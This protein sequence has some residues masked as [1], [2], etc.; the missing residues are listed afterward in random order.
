IVGRHT[1][2]AA[3]NATTLLERYASPII[4]GEPTGSS[5]NFVGEDNFF[6][7]PFSKMSVSVSDLYWQASWPQDERVWI[8]PLLLAPPTWDSYRRNVDP[9]MEA[10]KKFKG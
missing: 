2:S 8:A 4:V 10:V 7:L 9:A 5:P 3:Q 6:P 1:F